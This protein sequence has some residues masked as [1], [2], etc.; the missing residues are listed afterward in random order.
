MIPPRTCFNTPLTAGNN[1]CAKGIQRP[2][3]DKDMHKPT[4]TAGAQNHRYMIGK[5]KRM[6]YVGSDEI[7]KE[8]FQ[9]DED[10]AR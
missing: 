2:M 9:I 1:N 10:V 4:Q 6:I 7:P 5:R 8:V 3:L